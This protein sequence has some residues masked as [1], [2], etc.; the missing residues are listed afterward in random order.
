MSATN[1]SLAHIARPYANALYE[2]ARA[3]KSI[4]ST[5]KSLKQMASLIEKNPDFANL[6]ASP[7]VSTEEKTSVIAA[8]LKKAKYPTIV[9]NFIK[10][11]ASNSR[12]FA[13]PSMIASFNEIAAKERKEINAQVTSAKP[14]SASQLKSLSST[15]KKKIGKT[16]KLQT[17]VDESLIGGL[18]VKVGSQ[19]IDNSLLTKLSAMKNAMKEVR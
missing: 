8:I 13:L 12:L 10:L 11:V 19:M 7:V 17:H 16:V 1:S 9:A 6:L 15:L 18:I 4:A 3:E 14:L 2:L 5:E